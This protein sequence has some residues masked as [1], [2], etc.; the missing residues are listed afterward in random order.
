MVKQ[1]KKSSWRK[2]NDL[3][4]IWILLDIILEIAGSFFE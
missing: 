3:P 4:G 2:K 1:S